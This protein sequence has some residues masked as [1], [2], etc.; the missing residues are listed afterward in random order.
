MTLPTKYQNDLFSEGDWLY[1]KCEYEQAREYFQSIA[2]RRSSL[3]DTD[4]IR[5]YQS[6]AAT[7]VELKNY[8]EALD[9]YKKLFYLLGKNRDSTTKNDDLMSCCLSIGK[10][11]WLK[12]EYNNAIIYHRKALKYAPSVQSISDFYKNLANIH[13]SAKNTDVALKYFDDAIKFDKEHSSK[14]NLQIGQIYAN[15]G[16]M[17]ELEEKHED[18][19]KYFKKALET[20][21]DSLPSSYVGIRKLN[22]T[23][24]QME[25]KYATENSVTVS[26]TTPPLSIE[27]LDSSD[28]FTENGVMILWLD[29]HIGRDE[30]CRALKME[31]R[32][33]TNSF[34]MFDSPESFRQ[35]LP[36]VKDRKLFCIIQGKYAK[37]VVP[38]IDRIVSPSMKPVV[39]IFCLHIKYLVEWALGQECVMRGN[40]FTHE[41]DLLDKLKRDVQD[42]IGK[43]IPLEPIN[44][45]FNDIIQIVEFCRHVTSVINPPSVLH[46]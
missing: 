43:N 26:K 2:N 27:S 46:T 30:N 3:S 1:W 12:S 42:Y 24:Q 44:K 8:N 35:C 33:I 17:Y 32:Q 19:L 34:K 38:D 4:L 22:K 21:S 5:C 15:M 36:Y 25:M 14:S 10:V 28:I 23:I 40:I 31:F 11:Y 13:T 7:E 29:E 6:L 45:S 9:I 37:E 39:Y 41:Q 18:A 20:L 16:A